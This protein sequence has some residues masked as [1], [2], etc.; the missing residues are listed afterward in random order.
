MFEDL[1]KGEAWR[2]NPV[3]DGQKLSKRQPLHEIRRGAPTKVSLASPY[4]EDRG[5]CE[6]DRQIGQAIIYHL[7]LSRP[8]GV[9]VYLIDEQLS[10]THMIE[11]PCRLIQRVHGEIHVIG[12]D[13]ERSLRR[14]RRVGVLQKQGSLSHPA[15]THQAKHAAPPRKPRVHVAREAPGHVRQKAQHV[16]KEFVHA[17]SSVL[18]SYSAYSSK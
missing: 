10:A 4:I 9:L 6:R 1:G 8:V 17:H 15:R 7:E 13:I 3:D 12:C 2:L 11:L 14:A 16:V 5:S 18:H